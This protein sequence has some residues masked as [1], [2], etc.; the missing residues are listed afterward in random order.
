MVGAI[1]GQ[2]L[3][4]R[5]ITPRLRANSVHHVF[6]C[7]AGL[8]PAEGAFDKVAVQEDFYLL[9]SHALCPCNGPAKRYIWPVRQW[10]PHNGRMIRAVLRVG[11]PGP[12]LFY[13]LKNPGLTAHCNDRVGKRPRPQREPSADRVLERDLSS[14]AGL[15]WRG[16][17]ARKLHAGTQDKQST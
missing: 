14:I 17:H 7:S 16:G 10:I 3:A 11:P 4:V 2:A 5:V 9:V 8:K 6:W 15:Q 12:A 1:L 13:Y